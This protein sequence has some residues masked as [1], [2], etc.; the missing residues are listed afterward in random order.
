MKKQFI[1]VGLLAVGFAS[2]QSNDP[3]EGRVGINTMT[4]SATLNIKSLTGTNA[5]TKN[6]ELENANGTKMVTVLD[7]GNVG[8]GTDAPAE[9]LNV[10]GGIRSTG[11]SNIGGYLDLENT[12]KTGETEGARWRLYNMTD[13]QAGTTY[14]PGLH[15]WNYSTSVIG[16][17]L[18]SKML[19]TDELD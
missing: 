9:K 8:I 17:N 2:A 11:S 10:V 12:L 7:N 19:L 13:K 15:F 16:S 6:F 1:L 4:P 5:T 3:Y 18:G 14:T